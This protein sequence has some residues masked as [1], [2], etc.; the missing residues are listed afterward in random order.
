MDEQINKSLKDILVTELLQPGKIK[1]RS[2]LIIA[3]IIVA[4]IIISV[5]IQ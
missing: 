4:V 5:A 1:F 3:I 2:P